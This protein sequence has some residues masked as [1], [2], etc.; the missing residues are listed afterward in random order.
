MKQ[1][2]VQIYRLDPYAEKVFS[3]LVHVA[4]LERQQSFQVFFLSN[5]VRVLID[6]EL[7][8]LMPGDSEG[9]RALAI[10]QRFQDMGLIALT[11]DRHIENEYT[12]T[13]THQAQNLSDFLRLTPQQQRQRLRKMERA[14]NRPERQTRLAL[15]MSFLALLISVVHV[16]VTGPGTLLLE[17]VRA[18]FGLP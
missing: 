1:A 12:L 13:L 5:E 3:R 7:T 15:W 11:P 17:F 10:L 16:L 6:N 2:D 18:T 14:A 4:R 9:G 8:D